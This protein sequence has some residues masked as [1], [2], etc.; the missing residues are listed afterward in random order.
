MKNKL[1]EALSLLWRN[2]GLFSAIVLTVNLPINA[3][4]ELHARHVGEEG[5]LG[6]LFLSLGLVGVFGPLWTG[7]LVYA[8]WRL[9]TGQPVT[10]GVA[11]GVGLRKWGRLFVVRLVAGV[12]VGLGC[13]G[14]IVPG[15]VLALRYALIDEI[16]V[17]EDIAV[18]KTRSRSGRLMAG[19]KGPLLGTMLLF[20]IPFFLLSFL[21]NLAS[22]FYR[23][24]NLLPLQIA[25]ACVVSVAGAAV[26][27]VL[28]L[29]YWE[30]VQAETARTEAAQAEAALVETPTDE[31]WGDGGEGTIT[32]V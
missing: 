16:V 9:R 26:E 17:L 10:Y 24:L 18:D 8:L 23:S 21:V 27:I 14:L 12:I 13:L 31:P 5:V 3:V 19:R 2:L 32:P 20:M 11:M 7:A 29:Y 4:L 1:S 22:E 28:F 15:M 6:T 30:A 25:L